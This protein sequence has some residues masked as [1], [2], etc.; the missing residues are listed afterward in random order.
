MEL[1]E[2]GDIIIENNIDF[3]QWYVAIGTFVP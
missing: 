2:T 3:P 1:A